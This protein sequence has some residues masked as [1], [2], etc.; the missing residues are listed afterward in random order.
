[1]LKKFQAKNSPAKNY[2]TKNYSLNAKHFLS[3]ELSGD[4]LSARRIIRSVQKK[5]RAKNSPAKNCLGEEL[6]GK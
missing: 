5:I 2:P 4:E 3:A 6:S 1:M